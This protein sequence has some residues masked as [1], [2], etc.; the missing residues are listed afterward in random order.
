MESSVEKREP[1]N[2]VEIEK[3]HSALGKFIGSAFKTAFAMLLAYVILAIALPFVEPVI[4]HYLENELLPLA[5][6]IHYPQKTLPEFEGA[7]FNLITKWKEG[8]LIVML[9]TELDIS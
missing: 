1:D 2:T 3:K 8:R 5:E 9:Q 4:F 6:P 7:K